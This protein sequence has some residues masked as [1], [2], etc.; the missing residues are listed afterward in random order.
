MLLKKSSELKEF[1]SQ[2]LQHPLCLHKEEITKAIIL[3]LKTYYETHDRAAKFLNKR[4]IAPLPDFFVETVGFFLKLF[5]E[6]LNSP[7]EVHSER[8]LRQKRGSLRPDISIW[9]GGKVVAIIEC[10]T[11][12][13]FARN[14]W[15]ETF[16]KREQKLKRIS[17]TA[18]AFLLVLTS[19]NWSGFSKTDERVGKQFFCL[20]NEGMRNIKD[21][22]I[23]EVIENKIEHMFAQ[24]IEQN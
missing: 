17:P 22:P 24:I 9:N 21:R 20:C 4:T 18:K 5:L 12:L 7:L 1:Y 6:Q 8:P 2:A 14:D 19:I 13:G 23:D 3:R 11:N 10:K 15:E 16:A